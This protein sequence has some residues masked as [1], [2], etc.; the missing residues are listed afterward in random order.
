MGRGGQESAGGAAKLQVCVWWGGVG[1]S[2]SPHLPPLPTQAFSTPGHAGHSYS[3]LPLSPPL[4]PQASST[5]E[6][7]EQAACAEAVAGLLAA[8]AEGGPVGGISTATEARPSPSP[9][10]FLSSPPPPPPSPAGWPQGHRASPLAPPPGWLLAL[11]RQAMAGTT[12]ELSH[13]WAVVAR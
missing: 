12:L 10:P 9:S 13:S 8:G 3:T 6:K 1:V 7:A 11:L 4:P 5:A 2:L